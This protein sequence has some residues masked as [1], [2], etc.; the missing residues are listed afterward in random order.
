MQGN[1]VVRRG[2]IFNSECEYLVNPTNSIG[3]MGAGLAKQ[4]ATQYPTVC[5]EYNIWSKRENS[6]NVLLFNHL[7][8][9]PVRIYNTED[10]KIVMFTTKVHWRNNSHVDYITKSF[11]SLKEQLKGDESIALPYVGAGLG[12]LSKEEVEK[13][14]FEMMKDHDGKVEL[15]G[16]D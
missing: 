5:N 14:I 1:I 4:F 6:R 3:I 2:N 12:G 15:W 10:K 16:Y 9:L 7:K 13:I 11:L 8:L